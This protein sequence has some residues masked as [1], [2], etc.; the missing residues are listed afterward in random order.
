[1]ALAN[2]IKCGNK[3]S[4]R[5]IKCPKCG[6]N[7][8]IK[9]ELFCNICSSPLPVNFQGTCPECGDPNPE[10]IEIE[11]RKLETKE[12]IQ[13]TKTITIGK[14][15]VITNGNLPPEILSHQVSQQGT[16]SQRLEALEKELIIFALEKFDWVQ[17]KAAQSL[18]IS[19]RVLR[20]KMKKFIISKE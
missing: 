19:E 10:P 1:M 15:S 11:K 6:I 9:K 17:T 14:G 7:D 3:I 20:Y 2:C 8:P 16:L 12:K 4:E 13:M 18:G 5:A